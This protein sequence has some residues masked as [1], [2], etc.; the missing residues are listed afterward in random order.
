MGVVAAIPQRPVIRSLSAYF[1]EDN[2]T[3]QRDQA[4]TKVSNALPSYTPTYPHITAFPSYSLFEPPIS[5]IVPMP[6]ALPSKPPCDEG[7]NLTNWESRK[8]RP[9][10][11]FSQFRP[12]VRKTGRLPLRFKDTSEN[13]AEANCTKPNTVTDSMDSITSS[14]C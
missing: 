14:K 8:K 5:G 9:G 6:H 11:F 12:T 1:D 7:P 3:D 4:A 2:R 10:I 13:Y